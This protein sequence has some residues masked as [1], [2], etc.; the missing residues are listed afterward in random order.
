ML[1]CKQASLLTSRAMDEKLSFKERTGLRLHLMLC[2]SCSN[3]TKQL[4]FL[5]KAANHFRIELDFHLTDEARQRIA[6]SL[7]NKQTGNNHSEGLH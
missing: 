3:F 5:R 6:E 2:R 1:N 7:K 4:H